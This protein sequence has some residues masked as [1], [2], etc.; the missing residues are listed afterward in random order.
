MADKTGNVWATAYNST[1]GQI[2]ILAFNANSVPTA[3]I[4]GNPKNIAAVQVQQPYPY[5]TTSTVGTEFSPADPVLPLNPAQFAFNNRGHIDF[6]NYGASSGNPTVEIYANLSEPE[7]VQ[8]SYTIAANGAAV[9]GAKITIPVHSNMSWYTILPGTY[10][11]VTGLN[12]VGDYLYFGTYTGQALGGIIGRV[13]AYPY[14]AGAVDNQRFANP[15]STDPNGQQVFTVYGNLGINSVAAPLAIANGRMVAV[16]YDSI[17][18]LGNQPTLVADNNRLVEFDSDGNATWSVDTTSTALSQPRVSGVITA[19]SVKFNRPSAISQLSAN[20][21]LVVDTGNNRVVQIDRGGHVLWEVNRFNPGTAALAPGTSTRLNQPTGCEV[22]KTYEPA[23]Q[24]TVVHYLIADSGNFRVVEISD[25]YNNKG[26]LLGLPHQLTW[27]SHTFDSLGRKYRY[28]SASYYTDQ[29]GNQFV[30]ALVTNARI[31]QRI[32]PGLTPPLGQQNNAAQ[33]GQ[34]AS[35]VLMDY[36]NSATQASGYISY[37]QVA[38]NW[39]MQVTSQLA[40]PLQSD[41]QFSFNNG[42]LTQIP[43][44]NPRFLQVY[45]NVVAGTITQSFLLAQDNGVFDMHYNG[46]FVADWG[47]TAADYQTVGTPLDAGN[48]A[49]ETPFSRALLNPFSPPAGQTGIPFQAA[50]LQRLERGKYLVTNSF[51][52]GDSLPAGIGN[53]PANYPLFKGEA[54]VVSTP[55]L[56]GTLTG[57]TKEIHDLGLGV[58]SGH[59]FAIP[60]NTGQLT[61]PL[62]A[63]RPL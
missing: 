49:S 41:G 61:Q 32:S 55:I 25:T 20:D 5:D 17:A 27:V 21:Y 28:Q 51:S 22:V 33:D 16:G 52:L 59:T 19:A 62:Y 11:N 57:P 10:A 38:G 50:C 1:S 44:H 39:Q 30:A 23:T 47:F 48:V 53:Y 26:A 12:R 7:P 13:Y 15:L 31:S 14:A 43:L 24:N 45:T 40:A 58:Y 42:P 56:N 8:V 9:P 54:L 34:G 46:G 29:S 60:S 35:I 2:A 37:R 6:N 36:A 4:P 18:A 63:I 3:D